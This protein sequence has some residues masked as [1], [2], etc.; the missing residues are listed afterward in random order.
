MRVKLGVLIALLIVGGLIG[1]ASHEIK[2]LTPQPIEAYQL[3]ETV[4]GVM[5][6]AEALS[7][8]EKAEAAFSLDLTEGGFAPILLVMENQSRDN[9]L[10]LKDEIELMDSRGNVHRPTP[11]NVMVEKFKHNKM[12]YALLG[13]GIFSYMSAEEANKKMRSDWGSKE[14]PAEKI[15]LPARKTHGVVYFELGPGLDTLPNSTLRVP[16]QNLRTGENHFATFRIG[17]GSV[18][19]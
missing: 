5:I 18:E 12:A 6:A 1:C 17:T 7:T 11:T 9:I 14:L 2:Q 3:R 13:F 15:L 8:K 10:V 16:L 4:A 19:K